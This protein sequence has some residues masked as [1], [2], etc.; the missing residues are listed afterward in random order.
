MLS[1]GDEVVYIVWLV[2][3]LDPQKRRVGRLSVSGHVTGPLNPT[4]QPPTYDI[5]STRVTKL[6]ALRRRR[7]TSPKSIQLLIISTANIL[8]NC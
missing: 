6:T 1:R 5:S 3:D 8:T 4:G 7:A 2:G